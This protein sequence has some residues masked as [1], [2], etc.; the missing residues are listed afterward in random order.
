MLLLCVG[1]A[2]NLGTETPTR[3]SQK[4]GTLLR[5]CIVPMPADVATWTT[6][7]T[8]AFPD[9][10]LWIF[11][12]ATLADG[13]TAPGAALWLASADAACA[14][15]ADLL[16]TPDGN[17]AA[18]LTLDAAETSANATRTDGRWLALVPKA[19]FSDA[20]VG[21]LYYD[22][23]LV[24]PGS[25]DF[26]L[27][28]T[29]V[30][31]LDTIAGTCTRA[32]DAVGSTVLWLG[33]ELPIRSAFV[34]AGMAYL[35]ACRQPASLMQSCTLARVVPASAEMIS[36]YEYFDA[37]AGW[38]ASRTQSTQVLDDLALVS[39]S[40][41]PFHGRYTV[42]LTDPFDGKVSL[43]LTPSLEQSFGSQVPL[44]TAV[45]PAPD[46]L[47]DGGAEQ[48]SLRGEGGRVIHIAYTAGSFATR[49]LHLASFR[50]DE[51]LK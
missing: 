26:E 10:A 44:F 11:Q 6:P 18:F 1:C 4:A 49:E 13:S 2:E 28:G 7:A 51:V 8:L 30:C 37:F 19:G 22:H 23:V 40:S 32:V 25:F 39:L 43:R 36:A 27:L 50:F 9:G 31:V 46:A 33:D 41:N 24:G 45:A 12:S 5:E 42:L 38:G 29:G 48:T 20:G 16:R 34:D 14:G 15:P 35:L 17:L 47:F 21:H 3:R